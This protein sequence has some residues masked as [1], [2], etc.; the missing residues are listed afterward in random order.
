MWP[1]DWALCPS[2]CNGDSLELQRA[3]KQRKDLASATKGRLLQGLQRKKHIWYAPPP[4]LLGAWEAYLALQAWGWAAHC[5]Q[6]TG[7]GPAEP[8]WT[9]SSSASCRSHSTGWPPG[10][11][12][13]R[14]T[15][16]RGASAAGCPPSRGRTPPPAPRCPARPAAAP[17]HTELPV[18]WWVTQTL[19]SYQLG[20]HC[21][22][23]VAPASYFR[24]TAVAEVTLPTHQ[25][26]TKALPELLF[27]ELLSLDLPLI[28]SLYSNKETPTNWKPFAA[29]P[30]PPSSFLPFLPAGSS[31]WFLLEV[32]H[33][34]LVL[35]LLGW[36]WG[37]SWGQHVMTSEKWNFQSRRKTQG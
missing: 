29:T 37:L 35:G 25:L 10:R 28:P 22:F 18:P 7:P 3:E 24:D 32:T 5:H 17:G 33:L 1:R 11:R 12:S 19:T 30:A 14:G 20:P 31:S 8:L 27:Q 15:G 4:H 13:A 6:G 9:S 34:I 16:S 21:P 36:T 26:P 2:C 23:F